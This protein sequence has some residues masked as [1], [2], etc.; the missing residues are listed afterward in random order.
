MFD[1]PFDWKQPYRWRTNLRRNLAWVLNG[2]FSKGKDCEAV[3]GFH[4]WYNID[5]E[6]SGCYHCEVIREGKLW[7]KP[8]V[9]ISS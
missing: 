9:E 4:Q 7:K 8:N 1:F 5:N 2:L 3:G 6:D